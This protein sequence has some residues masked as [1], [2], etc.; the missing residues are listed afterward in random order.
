V[1]I[2]ALVEVVA[3]GLIAG[4]LVAG[5]GPAYVLGGIAIAACLAAVAWRRRGY[6]GAVAGAAGGLALGFTLA[7]LTLAPSDDPADVANL[8][9]PAR[10]R[11]VGR[12]AS[13][14][15]VTHGRTTLVLDA[16]SFDRGEGPEQVVGCVRLGLRGE[17]P[18]L[19]RGTVV[20]LATTLR[21]P[22]NFEL[23][24]MPSETPQDT[25][26][27][28]SFAEPARRIGAVLVAVVRWSGSSVVAEKGRGSPLRP[29]LHRPGET[30]LG[31][32]NQ[33]FRRPENVP[34]FR[35]LCGHCY[36]AATGPTPAG[37]GA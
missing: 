22:R 33:G 16:S 12:I 34:C 17:R 37:N 14:P 4:E 9:L 6:R 11:L 31:P 26:R 23:C 21:R 1:G 30:S 13:L 19:A 35:G 32:R 24:S 10:G 28:R 15:V 5:R 20:G 18:D 8:V 3:V 25:T 29:R 27:P 7:A 36:H 2:R